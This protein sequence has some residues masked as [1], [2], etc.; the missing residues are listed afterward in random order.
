MKNKKEPRA[1]GIPAE[2]YKLSNSSKVSGSG[3]IVNDLSK[4]YMQ[5]QELLSNVNQ[6]GN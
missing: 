6:M 4:C 1:D 3:C 2:V 5:A